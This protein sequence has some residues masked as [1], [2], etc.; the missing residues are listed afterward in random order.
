[1][2]VLL[3]NNNHIYKLDKNIKELE[4]RVLDKK[5][6]MDEFVSVPSSQYRI[7]KCEEESRT[8]EKREGE[9]CPLI[10]MNF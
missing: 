10:E 8:P 5:T 1:M 3:H 4:I 9:G 2:F 7:V 6:K